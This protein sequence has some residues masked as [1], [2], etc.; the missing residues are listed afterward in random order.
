MIENIFFDFFE[1]FANG[2]F[3]GGVMGQYVEERF[4]ISV[5]D[6]RQKDTGESWDL[7]KKLNRAEIQEREYW[8]MI[9]KTHPWRATPQA[10]IQCTLDAMKVSIPG[11]FQI[12]YDLHK[13]GYN[14]Y[15]VSDVWAEMRDAMFV[16]YPWMQWMFKK[17]YFSCD[18]GQI[19]SDPDYFEKICEDAGVDPARSLFID[20]YDVNVN[21]AKEAGIQGI[22]FENSAQLRTELERGLGY[23]ES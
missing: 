17:C 14:L 9:L 5:D 11:T 22:V 19:K 21:R 13:R 7:W 1:V 16:Q 4:G 8:E 2:M 23:L 10:F 15:L 18:F 20:D 6:F 12:A 3:W